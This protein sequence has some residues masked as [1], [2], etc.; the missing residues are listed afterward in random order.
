M[1]GGLGGLPIRRDGDGIFVGNGLEGTACTD[2]LQILL[3][4]YLE[5]ACFNRSRD[6]LILRLDLVDALHC[7]AVEARSCQVALLLDLRSLVLV[8]TRRLPI[9]GLGVLLPG[10]RAIE[11]ALDGQP[12]EYF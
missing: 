7:V 11:Y 5:C 1:I 8:R 4:R 6:L 2:D 10:A 3:G 9:L 12:V